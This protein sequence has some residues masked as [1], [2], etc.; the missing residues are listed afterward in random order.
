MSKHKS[1]DE[2]LTSRGSQKRPSRLAQ[3]QVSPA[4]PKGTTSNNQYR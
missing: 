3:N 2:K 4:P 1:T